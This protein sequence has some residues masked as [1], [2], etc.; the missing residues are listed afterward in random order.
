M[1]KVKVNRV[2]DGI[3]CT[4]EYPEA[5]T[6]PTLAEAHARARQIA[7]EMVNE[8]SSDDDGDD[9]SDI[10]QD[11]GELVEKGELSPNYAGVDPNGSM[12][13]TSL[14][15]SRVYAYWYAEGP[16]DYEI[17]VSDPDYVSCNE[18]LNADFEA[19]REDAEDE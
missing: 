3:G 7:G 11:S 4:N 1:F 18:I 10:W 13:G 8:A 12:V 19:N 6:F 9:Y 2:D 14:P 16:I 17:I 15:K 5:E